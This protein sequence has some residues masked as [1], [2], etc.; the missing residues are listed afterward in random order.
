M[1]SARSGGTYRGG[2]AAARG[3]IRRNNVSV[4]LRHLRTHGPRSR[5]EIAHGLD[6]PNSTVS[7]LVATLVELGLVTEGERRRAGSIGRPHQ[8]VALRSGAL[9]GLGV[10]ISVNYIRAIALDLPG[11]V[12]LD[13]RVPVDHD[14]NDHHTTLDLAA[15]LIAGALERLRR[16]GTTVAGVTV[17]AP[18]QVDPDTGVVTLAANLGWSR[19]PVV[20]ELTDRLGGTTAPRIR[21]DNDARLGAVA[22]HRIAGVPDLLYITGEVGVGGGIIV[23][24]A[25]VLG[26]AGFAG[27]IGHMPLDPNGSPCPCGQRG[28]W[29]TM[30]GLGAFLQHAAAESDQA[31]DPRRDLEERLTIIDARARDND[32][33]TVA[34]VERIAADLGMGI[35]LLVNVLDPQVVV[36]G[37]YFSYLGDRL[38]DRTREHVTSRVVAPQRGGC[39]LRLSTLGFTSAARGAAETVLEQVFQ[40]PTRHATPTVS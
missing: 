37:G 1:Q 29:E 36:L 5:T 8:A 12:L 18:G 40:D 27:E 24:D 10:E 14:R 15:E 7:K 11:D 34:A 23:D 17:A 33:R 39:E 2:A 25:L 4:V 20:T 3:A 32:A 19:L 30:V 35:G 28:C 26:G 22:E 38:L 9:C 6:L 31:R 13:R 21:L 16:S